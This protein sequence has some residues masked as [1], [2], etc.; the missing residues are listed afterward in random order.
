MKRSAIEQVAESLRRLLG[1]VAAG[2]LVASTPTR[3]RIEGAVAALDAITGGDPAA[4]LAR[5]TEG[6]PSE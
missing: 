4:L 6:E 2:D 3:Y 1:Q 5:L